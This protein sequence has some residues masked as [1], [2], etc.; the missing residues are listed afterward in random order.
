[1][2][3][4]NSIG[5]EIRKL[6]NAKKMPIRK[7]S[8]LLDIDQSSLSKIE[9]GE[10]QPNLHILNEISTIFDVDPK[11]LIITFY[12]DVVANEIC[13]FVSFSE[14]LHTAEAKITKKR[15]ELKK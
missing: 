11:A 15:K 9:R 8:A 14:I 1:M 7:L 2:K 5:I 13:D 10:R 3:N 12:S 4:L 6:R